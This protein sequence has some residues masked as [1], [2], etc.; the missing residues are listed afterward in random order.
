VLWWGGTAAVALLLAAAS[1]FVALSPM[2]EEADGANTEAVR[3]EQ[4]NDAHRAEVTRLAAQRE[5]MP[6]LEAELASLR[7][8]FPTDLELESF[9]QRLADLSA[10]SGATVTS[11]SR[12]APAPN[13]AEGAG[14]SFRVGV[15]LT[16]EGNFEQQLR[17][18]SDLQAVDD[19][20]FLVTAAA[21]LGRAESMTITG[22]TFVLVDAA[23]LQTPEGDEPGDGS[24][25]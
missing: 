17:Y 15:V 5:N 16:V 21:D 24:T 22:H 13:D 6:E 7:R 3:V 25:P 11:V 10:R 1:W 4:L 12:A 18:L 19:R 14:R 2:L 9:V 23:A 20:L 8:Q